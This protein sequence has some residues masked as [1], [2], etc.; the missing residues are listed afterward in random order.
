MK[1]LMQAVGVCVL[2]AGMMAAVH[3][4]DVKAGEQVH[5]QA[6][7]ACHGTGAAGAPR[8][9]DKAAWA[10]RIE[11]GMDTLVKH[12]I[13]GFRGDK[14]FMPPKGGATHLSDEQV[15]NA[16]VYMVQASQ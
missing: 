16:V 8:T 14:G 9:G 12:A 6:C 10:P 4:D 7:F 1:T 3:A 15:R 5:Q 11:Q 2:G 13:E